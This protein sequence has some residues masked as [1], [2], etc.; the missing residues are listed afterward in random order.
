M[1]TKLTKLDEKIFE[2][3]ERFNKEER[4]ILLKHMKDLMI[5]LKEGDIT[6]DDSM[7]MLKGLLISINSLKKLRK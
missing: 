1:R 4:Q 7:E 3:M 5:Q 6:M 2:D